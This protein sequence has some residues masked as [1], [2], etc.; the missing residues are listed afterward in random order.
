MDKEKQIEKMYILNTILQEVKPLKLREKIYWRIVEFLN[1]YRK[2]NENEVV[3]SKEEKQK[4]LKEMYAQGKFDAIADLEKDYKVV[5]SKEEYEK[6]QNFKR[7]VEHSFEYIQGYDDGKEFAEKFYKPLVRAET[8]K[9]T[10]REILNDIGNYLKKYA[11]IHK[12]AE[13]AN[14][15]EEEYADGTPVELNSVW[16]VFSLHKNGYDTY[17]TMCELETNIRNIAL[18]HL[19]QE[20]EKDF[21][22]YAKQFGVDL[23]EENANRI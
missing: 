3:I 17:E 23:G 14:K 19:L 8:R 22:L 15:T 10:A 5:I 11:H 13:K 12:Y 2:I 7:N 16:E 6:Y 1:D 4:L 18:S 9:E 20:F 21:K